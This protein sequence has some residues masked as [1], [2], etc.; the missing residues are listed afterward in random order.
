MLQH[1]QTKQD[2]TWKRPTE[3]TVKSS[4]SKQMKS[5][6]DDPADSRRRQSETLQTTSKS[7]LAYQTQIDR[8]PTVDELLDIKLKPEKKS[9]RTKKKPQRF[10]DIDWQNW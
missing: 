5:T 1:F 4:I 7:I 6:V 2:L 10:A 3:Q 8:R 9:K